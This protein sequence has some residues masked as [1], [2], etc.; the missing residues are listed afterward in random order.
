MGSASLTANKMHYNLLIASM[1]KRNQWNRISHRYNEGFLG[2]S[3]RLSKHEAEK[4]RKH[5]GVL[6]VFPDPLLELHTTRSWDFMDEISTP[7]MS[8]DHQLG[9]PLDDVI[10]VILDTGIWPES[11]SFSDKGI[12]PVPWRWKG[13]CMEGP[14]FNSSNCNRK[15]IGARY[16][17]DDLMKSA[18]D[19][20]GHGTHVASIASGIEVPNASYYGLAN[21]TAKGGFPSSRIAVYRVCSASSICS[22]SSLLSAFTDAIADGVDLISISIGSLDQRHFYEDPIAI[23]AFHAV[24]KGITVVCSAGNDGPSPQSVKNVAPWILTVAATTIDRRLQSQILLGNNIIIMGE[25]L[26]F[27]ILSESAVYPLILVGGPSRYCNG[28]LIDEM[29]IKGSIV[30][31]ELAG[32]D[33]K[34]MTLMQTKLMAAG[35]VGLIIISDLL[36]L[37]AFNTKLFALTIIT[38]ND[39]DQILHYISSTRN[40]VATISATTT[41]LHSRPAPVVGYFSSRG[42]SYATPNTLKPDIGAPGVNILASWIVSN[43][44]ES[45]IIG[46]EP[47]LFNILSGTSMACPHVSGIA[48]AIKSQNPS[49]S[50]AA[51]K[52]AIMTTARQTNNLGRPITKEFGELATPMDIGAGQVTRTGGLHPGLI[53][54]LNPEDYHLFLCYYGYNMSTIQLISSQLPEGFS[55]PTN[56]N[57]DMISSINFPSIVISQNVVTSSITVQRTVTNVDNFDD[58]TTYSVIVDAPKEL[59][60]A[61]VPDKLEFTRDTKKLTYQVR[62][63]ASPAAGVSGDRFGAITWVNEKHT[64]RIPFVVNISYTAVK[65]NDGFTLQYP[66]LGILLLLSF[67]HLRV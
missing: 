3:A 41:I 57:V 19:E 61:V 58:E 15:L 67:I 28:S 16:Y 63:S 44:S 33:G 59:E 35:G 4:I 38:S 54:E 31:C 20:V 39:A 34:T 65:P 11:E 24:E 26:D 30:L 48:A 47:P 56:S 43:T 8:D 46:R 5:A 7:S 23:G 14:D 62:F 21:G 66:T 49:W 29:N 40:P 55:C 10:I 6:S 12:G 51:V 2:F 52:S 18:R 9:P 45:T 22:G 36:S 32:I 27:S 53:Y 13:S 50:P 37:T 17:R 25:S 42:P 1:H 60:V 64:V